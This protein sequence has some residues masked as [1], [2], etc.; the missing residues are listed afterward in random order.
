METD[1]SRHTVPYEE[2]R[3]GGPARDG[4]PPIDDPAFI[5]AS[6]PPAYMSDDEP[7]ISLEIAGDRRAYPLASW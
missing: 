5:S 3:P 4:I 2:I 1:F 6:T 7:V